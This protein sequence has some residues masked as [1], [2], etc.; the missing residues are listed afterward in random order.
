MRGVMTLSWTLDHVGPMCKTVADAA[1]MM[2]VIAGYDPADPTT[3]DRPVPDYTRAI[4]AETAALRLG[5]ARSPFFEGLDPEVEAAVEEALDVLRRLTS[6]I[7]EVELAV[8]SV[9][10]PALWGPEAH[11]YHQP[12]LNASGDRYQPSTRES[13]ERLLDSPDSGTWD[14]LVAPLE[15]QLDRVS[16]VWAPVRHLHSVLSSEALRMARADI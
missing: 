8:P 3:A 15:Y 11:A 10:G 12:W 1:L 6:G 2:N 5:V 9:S 16:R 4:G 7:R 14:G 13:L